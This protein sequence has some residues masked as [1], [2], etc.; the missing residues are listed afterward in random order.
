MALYVCTHTFTI[1]ILQDDTLKFS[2][3]VRVNVLDQLAWTERRPE[4]LSE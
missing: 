4:Y 2:P 3:H 1:Q